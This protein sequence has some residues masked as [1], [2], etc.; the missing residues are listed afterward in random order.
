MAKPPQSSTNAIFI[1]FRAEDHHQDGRIQERI[2]Q[3]EEG[4]C[5]VCLKAHFIETPKHSLLCEK[6]SDQEH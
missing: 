6:C 1:S 2:H 5:P 4:K 3:V